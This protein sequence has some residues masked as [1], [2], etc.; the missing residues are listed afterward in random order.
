[1]SEYERKSKWADR[2]ANANLVILL[3]TRMGTRHPYVVKDSLNDTT[4]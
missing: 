4:L 1:M 3:Y 2:I